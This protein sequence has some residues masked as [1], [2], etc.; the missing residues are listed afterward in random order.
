MTQFRVALCDNHAMVRAG[1]RRTLAE[2]EGID[3][4]GEPCLRPKRW[5]WP[6]PSDRT[7]SSWASTSPTSAASPRSD[8]GGLSEGDELEVLRGTALDRTNA[9]IADRLYVLVRT[10]ETHRARIRQRLDAH[11]RAE[12]IERARAAHLLVDNE[13]DR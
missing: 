4:V 3:V 7:C 2:E 9:E 10:V 5:G 6:G 8:R 13:L 11:T 1:L 12:L